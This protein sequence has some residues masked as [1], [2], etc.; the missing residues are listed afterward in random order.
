MGE[1]RKSFGGVGCVAVML[2]KGQQGPING[3]MVTPPRL[4]LVTS[5]ASN[6]VTVRGW[7]G[8]LPENNRLLSLFSSGE[9]DFLRQR[10]GGSGT[11][12][13]PPL[14]STLLAAGQW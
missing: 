10:R 11:L 7:G 12:E 1:K 13:A 4:P 3:L 14:P 9:N 8:S 6:Q 2:L 5:S